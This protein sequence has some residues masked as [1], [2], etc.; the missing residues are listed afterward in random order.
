MALPENVE[1][2]F[3]DRNFGVLVTRRADGSPHSTPV[4][5]ETDGEQIW[6]NTNT[7]RAKYKHLQNDPWVAVTVLPSED[8][9]SGFVTVYGRA[10]D[11]DQES[12]DA[13]IDRLAQKYLGQET[14]PW[15]VP[16]EQ[17]V[18]IRIQPERFDGYGVGAVE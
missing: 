18:T 7:V 2:L 6:F 8:L 12:G 13:D 4:W 14:Y 5:I 11:F 17:R 10:V 16:G 9:Q 15:R 3:H 1:K